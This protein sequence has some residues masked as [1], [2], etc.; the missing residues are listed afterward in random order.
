MASLHL[1]LAV[2][3]GSVLSPAEFGNPSRDN[4]PETWFHLIGGNVAKEGLDADLDAIEASG[5]SG[6]Q[7]FHGRSDSGIW[8]CVT[9]PVECLSTDWDEMIRYVA[10]G[11]KKRSLRFIMQNCPGWSMSGGPWIAP[12]NAM[13]NLA[14]SRTDVKGGRLLEAELPIPRLPHP[15][16]RISDADRDYRDLFVLAFPT[17]KD[18]TAEIFEQKPIEKTDKD[19]I[20][21]LVF[22]FDSPKAFRSIQVPPP[23]WMNY[24]YCYSPD[25]KVRVN[26]GEWRTVP[27]GCWQ[28]GV[29]LTLSIGDSAPRNEWVVEVSHVRG[30]NIAWVRFLTGMRLDN[31]EGKA[32][33]V[34]RGLGNGLD[35]TAPAEYCIDPKKIVDLTGSFKDGVLKWTAPEGDW[36]VLRIG[37]VNNGT[38]NGPAPA[39][40]TGWECSKMDRA[41]IDAHF[42]AYIGRLNKGPLAGGLLKGFVVDSWECCRQTWSRNME[43]DFRKM[44]GYSL[45]KLLP[46]VFGWIVG[47]AGETELFLR[48]WRQT[49]GELVERNYYARMA[50]LARE[51]GMTALYETAFGDVFPG[52]ILA[53]W[54]HC[55]T[56]MCEFWFPRSN[57]FVGSD[58]FKPVVPCA[59]AAH[60][61]GKRRVAAEAFTT[62]NLQWNEDLKQLKACGNHA[63]AQGVTHFVFHTYTHNPQVGFLPPGSSFGRKIGTPFLRGQTWW[64]CMPSFTAWA[65][66]CGMMLESGKPSNDILWY[67]GETLDHK[68][69]QKS[70]FPKGYRY[71]YLN[72]D[73]LLSRISVKDGKFT[74]PEGVAWKVMWVPCA[75]WMSPEVASRLEEFASQGGR[76][77]YG[78]PADVVAG[79]EPDVVVGRDLMGRTITDWRKGEEQVEWLHRDGG[80]YDLYFAAANGTDAYTGEVKF[81]AVGECAVWDPVTGRISPADVVARTATSTTLRLDLAPAES[82]FVV[83]AETPE[84]AGLES[85]AFKSRRTAGESVRLGKWKL[86]FPAGWGAPSLIDLSEFKSWTELPIS[87]EGRSFSGTATYVTDFVAKAGES[88]VLDLGEVECVADVYVNGRKLCALWAAPYRAE[89]PAGY[90]RDGQNEIRVDVTSTWFNRL[91]FDQG[92]E[93]AM[94][95]TWTIAAPSKD[96]KPRSA[97][98][99]GPVSLNRL[100]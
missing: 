12:S 54:K 70:P 94:R 26:G 30:I 68:P 47:S 67:L 22:R 84:K 53:F 91:V 93:A 36:T 87:Q 18:D 46:A 81:R 24:G 3:M 72:T 15:E 14:Y 89:I 23:S 5:I 42:A 35:L 25:A 21:R 69:L 57:L 20:L 10:D 73:A 1:L 63:F 90:V 88:F 43:D 40:A 92:Q 74:T 100:K 28:D 82:V 59:S 60:I 9:N 99:L 83:F 61:Y 77:V 41:G 75:R 19:G 58:D 50:E 33:W 38:R 2:F 98:L 34:L 6:I 11:C 95:K 17:P 45:R 39:E 31:W 66:R 79:I 56:P 55:D 71:D 16:R 37:H 8:P 52:D 29:P 27:Q 86:S 76:I 97:G 32:G 85:A 13:R 44:R 65:A 96:A 7:L 48:D 80:S 64:K 51:Y 62:M 4:R 78:S 49:I